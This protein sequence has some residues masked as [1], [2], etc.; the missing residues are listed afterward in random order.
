MMWKVIKKAGYIWIVKGSGYDERSFFL[1]AISHRTRK[2]AQLIFD[3]RFGYPQG[4][5]SK[6]AEM[7]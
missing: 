2:R 7:R 1:R 4:K 3:K 5:P 6:E